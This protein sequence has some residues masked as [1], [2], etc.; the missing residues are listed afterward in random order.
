MLSDPTLTTAPERLLC[1]FLAQ[2]LHPTQLRELLFTATQSVGRTSVSQSDWNGLVRHLLALADSPDQ[3][4]EPVRD[5][6]NE[7]LEDP[8]V[9]ERVKVFLRAA[10]SADPVD[11]VQDASFLLWLMRERMQESLLAQQQPVTA[12]LGRLRGI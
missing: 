11:C 5:L 2:Y 8:S 4:S 6:I 9:R 10:A 3:T 12:P 7:V 1:V